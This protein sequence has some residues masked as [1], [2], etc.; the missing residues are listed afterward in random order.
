MIADSLKIVSSSLLGLSVGCA[1]CHDHRYDPISQKDY[2]QLR[3]IFDPAFGGP[4]WKTP[5]QRQVSLYTDEDRKKSA[6]IEEQAKQIEKEK[7]QKRVLKS[8]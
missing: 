4:G 2:Y 5:Q 6:E 1:E 3:A 8:T 7:Q